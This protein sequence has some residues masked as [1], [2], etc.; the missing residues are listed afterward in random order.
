MQVSGR[1]RGFVKAVVMSRR[2]MTPSDLSGP[3]THSTRRKWAMVAAELLVSRGPDAVR[4]TRLCSRMKVNRGTFY[5]YFESRMDLLNEMAGT[6]REIHLALVWRSLALEKDLSSGI[7]DYL[8]RLVKQTQFNIDY[9][10]AFREFAR[11]HAELSTKILAADSEYL[12]RMIIF[13]RMH[14]YNS[15]DAEIRAKF[16]A[17]IIKDDVFGPKSKRSDSLEPWIMNL[18]SALTGNVPDQSDVERFVARI[19]GS[20]PD[21]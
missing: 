2:K 16:L 5:Y 3:S 18:Y 8:E 6:W 19:H 7:F 1:C 9:D 21:D 13:F 17:R 15:L 14:G 20:I 12:S 10:H 11:N 4:V